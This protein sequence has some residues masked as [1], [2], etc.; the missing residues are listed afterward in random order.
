MNLFIWM[1]HPT[2]AGT[3]RSQAGAQVARVCGRLLWLA[4]KI[5]EQD[6][7]NGRSLATSIPVIVLQRKPQ[8]AVSTCSP[9]Q[10]LRPPPS[11]QQL[12]ALSCGANLLEATQ[13]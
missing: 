11:P 1:C 3:L 2:D 5:S 4:L 8:G 7:Q 12:G 13:V 9:H 10:R 6:Y